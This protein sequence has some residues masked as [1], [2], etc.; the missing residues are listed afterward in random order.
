MYIVSKFSWSLITCFT[1]TGPFH[2]LFQEEDA[3]KGSFI[4]I[5]IYFIDGKI[6]L[7]K[8]LFRTGKP[9]KHFAAFPFYMTQ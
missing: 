7:K 8:D 9:S 1:K 3:L 5:Y 6:L 4:S 2:V